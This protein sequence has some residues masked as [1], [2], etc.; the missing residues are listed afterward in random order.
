MLVK[1]Y[2]YRYRNLGNHSKLEEKKPYHLSFMINSK[3]TALNYAFINFFMSLLLCVVCV[4][5]GF[6]RS[7]F[8]FISW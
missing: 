4:V 2:C 5:N 1:Y 8:I 3:T 6:K 7:G